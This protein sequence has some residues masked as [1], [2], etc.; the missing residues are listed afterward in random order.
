M[1]CFNFTDFVLECW[2]MTTACKISY[3]MFYKE[4]HLEVKEY[5]CDAISNIIR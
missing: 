5:Y 1:P 2:T 3:K 4:N